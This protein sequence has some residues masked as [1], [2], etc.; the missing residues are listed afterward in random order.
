M[1]WAPDYRAH[2]R[3]GDQTTELMYGLETRLDSREGI[4]DGL[5]KRMLEIVLVSV[6]HVSEVLLHPPIVQVGAVHLVKIDV[7]GPVVKVLASLRKYSYMPNLPRT[8]S[9]LPAFFFAFS[10]MQKKSWQWRLG[11]R[12]PNLSK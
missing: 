8:Q 9:P 4:L 5:Q 7:A 1:V 11:T 10:N 3:S 6:V 12:L 2:V